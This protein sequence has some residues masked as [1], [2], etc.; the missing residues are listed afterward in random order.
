MS[1]LNKKDDLDTM[2]PEGIKIKVGGKEFVIKEFV[3]QDC[4]INKSRWGRWDIGRILTNMFLP[5]LIDS[6]R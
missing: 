3:R 1:E 5:A 4:L 2:Y 6:C